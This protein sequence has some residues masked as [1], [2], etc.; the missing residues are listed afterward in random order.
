[1]AFATRALWGIA[2]STVYPFLGTLKE[3]R[4]EAPAMKALQKRRP[5]VDPVLT[6]HKVMA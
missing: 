3:T 1:M 4:W 2:L 6:V 5:T